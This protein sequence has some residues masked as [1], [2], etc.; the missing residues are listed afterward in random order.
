MGAGQVPAGP[1]SN[2]GPCTGAILV[3]V[4][5]TQGVFWAGDGGNLRHGDRHRHHHSG[6]GNAPSGGLSL[7]DRLDA[8]EQFL[9]A[10]FDGL[11]ATSRVLKALYGALSATQKQIANEL[12]RSSTG[13]M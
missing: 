2:L 8:Q 6:A 9:A 5:L 4:S 11:R 10:R 3:L 13:M 12:I 1:D 7:P